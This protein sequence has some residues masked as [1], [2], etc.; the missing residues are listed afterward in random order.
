MFEQ[1]INPQQQ[2]INEWVEL[3]N[4]MVAHRFDLCFSPLVGY[5]LYEPTVLRMH[6]PF[7]DHSTIFL[8][9]TYG[10]LGKLTSRNLPDSFTPL[11]AGSDER[12]TAVEGYYAELTAEA[13][14][15]IRQAFPEDFEG[16]ASP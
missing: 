4:G 12:I 5:E 3:P 7:S 16:G 14:S 13:A 11:P 2:R 1:N 8:H 15:L 6:Y 10:R 9:D